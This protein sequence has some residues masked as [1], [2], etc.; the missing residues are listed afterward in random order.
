MAGEYSKRLMTQSERKLIAD[1]CRANHKNLRIWKFLLLLL[2]FGFGTGVFLLTAS[3]NMAIMVAASLFLIS[4]GY[5]YYSEKQVKS[6]FMSDEI[7]VTDAT[8][9]GSNKYGQ[10]SFEVVEKGVKKLLFERSSLCDKIRKGDSVILV[11]NK[12]ITL[13]YLSQ[14]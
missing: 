11:R 7:Y 10:A 8:F 1:K 3:I 5:I 4:F 12:G 6:L 9:I 2:L 13:V 14:S